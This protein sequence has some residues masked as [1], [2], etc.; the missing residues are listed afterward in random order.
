MISIESDPDQLIQHFE[1]FDIERELG[2]PQVVKEQTLEAKLAQKMQEKLQTK[3][4]E[5]RKEKELLK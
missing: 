4:E 2:S 5:E 3:L 1:N